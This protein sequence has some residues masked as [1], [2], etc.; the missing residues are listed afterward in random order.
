MA[1]EA[2]QLFFE[3]GTGAAWTEAAAVEDGEQDGDH[4][5]S[6]FGGGVENLL[7]GVGWRFRFRLPHEFVERDGDGLAQIHRRM[8]GARGDAE[9]KLAVAQIVIGE[10]DL[11]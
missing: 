1:H 4:P 9:E 5:L 7:G 10:A 2:A 11:F 6:L 8:F 3:R